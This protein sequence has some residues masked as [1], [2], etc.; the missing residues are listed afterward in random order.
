MHM[1]IETRKS[2]GSPPPSTTP[3]NDLTELLGPWPHKLTTLFTRDWC[4]KKRT[5]LDL[6]MKM[7]AYSIF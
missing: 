2:E 5:G 6:A 1:K 4:K 3:K 7:D